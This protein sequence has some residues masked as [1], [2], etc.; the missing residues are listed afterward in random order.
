MFPE[1]EAMLNIYDSLGAYAN[2]KVE[3]VWGTRFEI[4]CGWSLKSKM[5]SDASD[6][7]KAEVLC[8]KKMWIEI[9]KTQK[10]NLFVGS[11]KT[12]LVHYETWSKQFCLSLLLSRVI[13]LVNYEQALGEGKFWTDKRPCDDHKAHDGDIDTAITFPSE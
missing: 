7:F 9:E 4:S 12:L 3:T 10:R 2:V 1:Y 5:L 6:S 11:Y 13:H 8:K